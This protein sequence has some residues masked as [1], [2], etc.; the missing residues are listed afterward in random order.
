MVV[1]R[2]T[3]IRACHAFIADDC[4]HRFVL[5]RGPGGVGGRRSLDGTSRLEDRRPTTDACC[6]LY[7]RGRVWRQGERRMRRL[8]LWGWPRRQRGSEHSK[9][10]RTVPRGG[11][12]TITSQSRQTHD[13][14]RNNDHNDRHIRRLLWSR[15]SAVLRT[16][17]S[18]LP[19]PR[20]S[21]REI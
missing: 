10:E 5:G 13:T 7:G 8:F 6:H 18:G 2:Y 16:S 1:T 12:K 15:G 20:R 3:F 21:C 9:V 19:S 17:G 11:W 14:P 4:V